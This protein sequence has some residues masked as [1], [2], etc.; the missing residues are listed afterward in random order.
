VANSVSIRRVADS[1]ADSG[2]PSAQETLYLQM[3]YQLEHRWARMIN[4]F[5]LLI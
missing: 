4:V 5:R 2:R 3:F 1:S